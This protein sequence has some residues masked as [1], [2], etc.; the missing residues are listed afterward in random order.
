MIPA[1]SLVE[2]ASRSLRI[3]PA[4]VLAELDKLSEEASGL[5]LLE[6][7]EA[8]LA[9]WGAV[10]SVWLRLA[11]R[12]D[13]ARIYYEA[14]GDWSKA[15]KPVGIERRLS[16]QALRLLRARYLQARDGRVGET[17]DMMVRRVVSYVSLPEYRY[18]RHDEVWREFYHLI[19]G[20]R[21]LPNSPTLMNSGTRYPQLAACFVVPLRDDIDSIL[22]AVR[23]SAW[24]FKSGAG[25][26]YDFSPLRPRGAPISGTGGRSSGPVS[27]MR[28]FDTAADVLREGGKRRAAMMGILQDWHPDIME[29][30]E[31]KCGGE[32]RLESFNISVGA[33]DGLFTLEK[34]PLIDPHKC[35]D[36][37]TAEDPLKVAA[38]CGQVGWI[39]TGKLLDRVAECAWA[40]GDPGVVFL[41]EINRHN[42]T[43]SLGRI[44]AT[45]PCGE[46][47]LLDW[48]AC[49]LGSINLGRYVDPDKGIVRWEELARDVELAV[50]FLDDVIEVSWYPDKRIREAV[51]R[52]R[53]VGLGVM[54]WADMLA[55]LGIPYDS[56]DAVFFADKLMEFI[57]YHARRASNL[58]SVERGPYPAFPTS[59]HRQGRFNFEPQRP[60]NTL[61]S[62][63]EISQEVRRLVDD[64]PEPD[65][66]ILRRE[67]REGTR[68][69]TVTTIA[70]TGS[71]SIIAGVSSSI[72]PF[73]AL[74]YLRRSTIGT[75]IEVNPHLR[76]WL[77]ENGMLNR[78]T[79]LEIARHGGGIRWAPWAP[80]D[81]KKGLPTALEINW[82][83][84]VLIQA[85][86]QRWTDNAVSKTINMPSNTTP[87]EIRQAIIT[88]WK[89]GCKGVTIYRDKSRKEQVLQGGEELERA[90]KTI[91][92]PTRIRDKHI[93]T[94]LRI[95]DQDIM[96]VHEEYSG[97]CPT[98]DI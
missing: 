73:F 56:P 39:D 96:L 21:F 41:D 83:Y 43:P 52:T 78:E 80:N 12:I 51:L 11:A 65:W 86:F 24:V 13:L 62:Q 68:N 35:P 55:L 16:W 32:G 7:L 58:L 14:L 92:R 40:S 81:L 87:Q 88:A 64:R 76:Q 54:G 60:A 59:I 20:L 26:G 22:D 17:P 30:V 79:L 67:M 77:E 3:D 74:V 95:S 72:E 19:S 44:H 23:V 37:V 90:L 50:R 34:W 45:N 8:T 38:E 5:D 15:F 53:K 97:G 48:E 27:F 94:W 46:T 70:P 28:L 75:W 91:P 84:H 6:R 25:A 9:L 57:E 82:K 49:N 47:P 98:C 85:A 10:E 18:G 93:Y 36:A 69:A 63:D 89:L 33:H 66:D 2:E 31:S 1:R 71:I 29:F 42:P 61:Y 4:P